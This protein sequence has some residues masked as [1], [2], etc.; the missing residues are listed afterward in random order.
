MDELTLEE[1]EMLAQALD[2]HR[3]LIGE[4]T[5][6]TDDERN[7]LFARIDVLVKKLGI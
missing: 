5:G 2:D 1:K 4:N 6:I 7:E 3:E